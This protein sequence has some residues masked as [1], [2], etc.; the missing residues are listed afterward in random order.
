[1]NEKC[2]SCSADNGGGV[3]Y[4]SVQEVCFGSVRVRTRFGIVI[5]SS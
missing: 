1:M 3:E 4:V 5:D 2:W